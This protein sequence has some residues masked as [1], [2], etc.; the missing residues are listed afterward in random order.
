MPVFA[1]EAGSFKGDFKE[2]AEKLATELGV[3]DTLGAAYDLP[4]SM[5]AASGARTNFR[6]RESARV[7]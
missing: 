4:I 1:A 7:I 5:V 2:A 3:A 6:P